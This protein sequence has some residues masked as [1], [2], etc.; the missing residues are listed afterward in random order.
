MRALPD[1]PVLQPLAQ[2][3]GSGGW[4]LALPHCADAARLIWI[5]RGHG[6]ALLDG[7]SQG[8]APHT[9]FFVPAGTL[10]AL[11]RGAQAAG[12]VL[13]LPPA[14]DL[15]LPDAPLR[16]AVGSRVAQ[17]EVARLLAAMRDEAE[18]RR[19]FHDEAAR[20]HAALILIWLRRQREGL[21]LAPP[22]RPDQRLARDL[23]RRLARP[24]TAAQGIAAQ[25]EALAVTPTHLTRACQRAAGQSASD[26]RRGR[27]AHAARVAL[28]ESDRPAAQIA[29]DLGFASAAYFTRF[30]Q[31]QTGRTPSQLRREAARG[32][33]G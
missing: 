9:A 5:E 30:I 11:A 4:R 22:L 19:A 6:M 24:E 16:L 21:P 23:A 25:A 17:S 33:A 7:L 13:H 2:A 3:G 26:L 31:N 10:F 27:L 29:A 28:V 15:P 20:A 8:V 1:H 32:P 18:P 14:A 12:V